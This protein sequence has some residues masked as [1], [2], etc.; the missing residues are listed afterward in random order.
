MLPPLIALGIAALAVLAAAAALSRVP[1]LRRRLRRLAARL[2]WIGG[3][4]TAVLDEVAAGMRAVGGA[5]LRRVLLYSLGF[6]ATFLAQFALLIAALAPLHPFVALCGCAA[7]LLA[8]T[9]VPPV[10]LGELGI[11]EG[12]SVLLLGTVGVP[13]AAA[14]SASLLLFGINVLLPAVPGALLAPRGGARAGAA[15]IRDAKA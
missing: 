5:G 14:L 13:A 3:R 8:K 6:Y 9:V 7:V 2:P 12:A 1:F 10:T 4:L 11:R 15:G